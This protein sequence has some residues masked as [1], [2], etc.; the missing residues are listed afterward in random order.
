MA[1]ADADIEAGIWNTWDEDHGND[2]E[3]SE[4]ASRPSSTGPDKADLQDKITL[5]DWEMKFTDFVRAGTPNS[6]PV[7]GDSAMAT[8][9]A[10]STLDSP[11]IENEEDPNVSNA[12]RQ[13]QDGVMEGSDASDPFI[14]VQVEEVTL[15]PRAMNDRNRC[16]QKT[17]TAT[18]S[19]FFCF[20]C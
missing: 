3:E 15:H 17:V 18:K 4:N 9:Y 16:L 6:E 5:P 1:E 13:N 20:S 8:S 7:F 14:I 10:P 12:S 19:K 2:K 11:T